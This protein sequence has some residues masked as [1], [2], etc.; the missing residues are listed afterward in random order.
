MSKYDATI[1][2]LSKIWIA[3]RKGWDDADI[4]GKNYELLPILSLMYNFWGLDSSIL[5]F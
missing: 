3:D 2:I 5:C 1:E 4:I